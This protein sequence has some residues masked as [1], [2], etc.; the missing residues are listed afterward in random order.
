MYINA[1]VAKIIQRL[2]SVERG[3]LM[4]IPCAEFKRTLFFFTK[5]CMLPFKLLY[6]KKG[7]STVG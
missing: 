1:K 6:M 3:A 7:V 5:S 2:R 4:Q